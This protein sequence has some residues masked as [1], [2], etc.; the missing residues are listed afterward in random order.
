MT[1]SHPEWKES[2]L[3]VGLWRSWERASMAW[4]RSSVRSR[5]GPPINPL[6]MNTLAEASYLPPSPSVWCHLVSNLQRPLQASLSCLTSS[7]EKQRSR[8]FFSAS[9]EKFLRPRLPQLSIDRVDRGLYALGRAVVII[10]GAIAELERNLIIERVGRHASGP[11]GRQAYRPSSARHRS[12]CCPPG[13]RSRPE[14]H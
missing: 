4:K 9:F 1:C 14:S 3:R 11:A 10:I 7:Q 13:A 6:E 2:F 5:S 12:G 8:T